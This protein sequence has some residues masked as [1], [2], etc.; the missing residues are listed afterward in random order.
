MNKAFNEWKPKAI[1]FIAENISVNMWEHIQV[2]KDGKITI[3]ELYQY[4]RDVGIEL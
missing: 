4:Q 1:S 3:E 2:V